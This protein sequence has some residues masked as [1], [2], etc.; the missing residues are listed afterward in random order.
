MI[1]NYQPHWMTDELDSFRDLARRFVADEVMPRQ[2]KWFE[3]GATD[4]QI[5]LKAGEL[6]I[7]TPTSTKNTADRAGRSR[8]RPCSP[9]SSASQATPAGVSASRSMSSPRTTLCTTDRGTEA[10]VASAPRQR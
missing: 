4:R 5:W 10:P 9:T 1:P 6:G 8:T 2:E 7:L 3:L